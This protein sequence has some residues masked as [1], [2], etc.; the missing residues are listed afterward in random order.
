MTMKTLTKGQ[1]E[2]YLI[3]HP[4]SWETFGRMSEELRE[5][6]SQHLTYSE[7]YLQIM[8]PLMEH[9]NNNWFISRLIFMMAE[10]WDLNI[11]SVGSLTLKRDDIQKGVE[12]DACFYLQNEL[13]IR[14]KQHIDLNEGDNPPDLVIEID[15]TPGSLDKFPIY[16]ALGVP[17][18]WRYDGNKL[19]FYGLDQ[20][21]QGYQEMGHSLAFP[22]LDIR[23]IPHWLEQRFIIGETATLKQ[24]RQ[25][26][27]DHSVSL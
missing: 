26:V 24:I 6:P 22:L 17:E 4:I 5:S 8:S 12:P 11:K 16:G 7:G 1:A 13:K 2:N 25:W 15:I 21:T 19:R 27:R 14:N 20:E 9:E 18:I 10:E 3:L 23:L